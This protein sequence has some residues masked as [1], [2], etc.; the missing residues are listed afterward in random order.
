MSDLGELLRR[1]IELT[2]LEFLLTVDPHKVYGETV[3]EYVDDLQG[4]ISPLVRAEM[5]AA[6]T[7]VRA[8]AYVTSV[9]QFV[10]YSADLETALRGLVAGLE[11]EAAR[12]AK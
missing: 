10:V 12:R 7:I 3:E 4:E 6:G 2:P 8:G 9:T 1:A 5:I 11:V